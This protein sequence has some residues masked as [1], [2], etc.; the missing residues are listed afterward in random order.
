MR[1]TRH[2][3]P[4]G[5]KNVITQAEADDIAKNAAVVVNPKEPRQKTATRGICKCS[6]T[7]SHKDKG[8]RHPAGATNQ[9]SIRRA[10]FGAIAD[11]GNGGVVKS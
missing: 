3:R 6:T 8:R 11:L 1:K 4:A 10:Y 7:G 9:F 2:A 5:Q